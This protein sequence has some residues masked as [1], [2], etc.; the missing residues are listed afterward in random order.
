M[1]DTFHYPG[2]ID[3]YRDVLH[4]DDRLR[5]ISLQGTSEQDWQTL[6]DFLRTSTYS[7]EFTLGGNPQPLPEQVADIFA[8]DNK[9]D[10]PSLSIDREHL[11][12]NCHFFTRDEIEFDIDPYDYETDEQ[13]SRLLEFIRT[14]GRL[15]HKTIILTPEEKHDFA[16]FRFDPETNEEI[17]FPEE[18]YR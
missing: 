3:I 7:V 12:I 14:I 4:R 13:V 2:L 17:W 6:L 9:E 16:Y 18:Y 10:E 1:T 15:L 8:L 11:K 5:D